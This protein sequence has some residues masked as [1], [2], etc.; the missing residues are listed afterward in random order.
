MNFTPPLTPIDLRLNINPAIVLRSLLKAFPLLIALL[1]FAPSRTSYAEAS[2]TENAAPTTSHT[3]GVALPLTGPI[4]W[5][6]QA[7]QRGVQLAVEEANQTSTTEKFSL[8][9]EDDLSSNRASAVTLFKKFSSA[10]ATAAINCSTST[11]SAIAPILTSSQLPTVILWDSNRDMPALS[12][13]AIGFGYSNEKT[14][15]DAA[16]FLIKQRSHKKIAVLYYVNDWSELLTRSFLAKVSELGGEV[17]LSEQVD[18]ANTD[19]RT[20]MAKIK[21]S[22]AEALYLPLF[23]PGLTS[24]L[25]QMR[26]VK[27][28]GDVLTVDSLGDDE[29]KDAGAAAEGIFVSQIALSDET[30][31]A[32]LESRF[33]SARS[34]SVNTG[35]SALGYDGAKF[36]L[37]AI[38][39]S[40]L[41]SGKS[42]LLSSLKGRD[43]SGVLGEMKLSPQGVSDREMPIFK[44]HEGKFVSP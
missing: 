23:G 3:I 38:K 16:T 5:V 40:A 31:A 30:F 20:L 36:L 44:I 6:G 4:A 29:L 28:E 11:L 43:F 37:H 21:R 13:W 42:E 33:P 22:G 8:I 34:S 15:E 17:T 9:V 39:A 41:S 24:A 14:A 7:M 19:F 32:K 27:F 12:P 25:K 1:L 2:P 35:Y 18:G 10:G 26:D